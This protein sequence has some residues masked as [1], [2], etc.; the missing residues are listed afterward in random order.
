[1]EES[2]R[3]SFFFKGFKILITV[4]FLLCVGV[5]SSAALL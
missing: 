2:K 4:L 5:F 3:N 1:M